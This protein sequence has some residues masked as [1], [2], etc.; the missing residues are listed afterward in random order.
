MAKKKSSGGWLKFILG[1]LILLLGLFVLQMFLPS[2]VIPNLLNQPILTGKTTKI[3]ED[4]GLFTL[5][6]QYSGGSDPVFV[7]YSAGK[8]R[9]GNLA[10]YERIVAV[11][12]SMSP[13]GTFTYTF[14]TKNRKNYIADIDTSRGLLNDGYFFTYSKKIIGSKNL[15]TNLIR[16]IPLSNSFSL[17]RVLAL[18]QSVGTGKKDQYGNDMTVPELV[19][20]FSSNT[21]E[22]LPYRSNYLSMYMKKGITDQFNYLQNNPDPALPNAYQLIQTYVAGKTQVVVVDNTGLAYGYD[23]SNKENIDA[24]LKVWEPYLDNVAKYNKDF[25]AYLIKSNNEQDTSI[26]MPNYPSYPNNLV[27]PNIHF[28]KN[29]IQTTATL[30]SN[31]NVALPQACGVDPNTIIT[32]N[33]TDTDVTSIGNAGQYQ[34]YQLT[35][36]D[37]PLNKLEYFLKVGSF[38]DSD[39]H[40]FN[41]GSKPTY[42]EYVAR[43]PILLM[44]DFWGRWIALG[45]YDIKLMAGC[46]KPVVYLYPTKP[47]DVTV[48]FLAPMQLDT[49]IPV[50][51]NGWYVK[52]YPD[53]SLVDLQPEVT[54]CS[55]IDTSKKGS[56]YAKESCV[57]N[58]Y[59]YLYWSGS[60]LAKKYVSPSEGWIVSRGTLQESLSSKL[61]EIGFSPKE[62]QDMLSYWVPTMLEKNAPYYRFAFLQTK[63]LNALFPMAVNP[64]PTSIYRYFLDWSPIAFTYDLKPQ[65]LE[66][67]ERNGFTLVEW[68]GLKQ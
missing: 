67:I 52:A 51:Q 6:H 55:K 68:G 13:S 32:R 59:P 22:S 50:Y 12:D 33:V 38:P 11:V 58:N 7:Y 16:I 64:N 43:H 23:L 66:H 24:Y 65:Q 2:D 49:T 60:S 56:E 41:S 62:K 39:W 35:N 30:F 10:G 37:H 21:Y 18:T 61:D 63:Q 14:A 29:Q 1:L 25:E 17:L 5:H 4:L 27:E 40:Y 31:Y 34:L 45:E 57:K 53:G 47:T 42:S 3:S 9:F 46:G 44:K 8:Y 20:N 54:D 19:T 28:D 26:A 48:S 15:P 36:P